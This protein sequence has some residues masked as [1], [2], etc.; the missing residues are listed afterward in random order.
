[1]KKLITVLLFSLCFAGGRA[2]ESGTAKD[3]SGNAYKTLEIAGDWWMAENLKTG[4]FSN[5]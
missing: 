3:V 1:M 5:G 2:Q 4:K